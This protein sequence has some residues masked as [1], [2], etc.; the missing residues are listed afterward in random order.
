MRAF[1]DEVA[2]SLWTPWLDVYEALPEPLGLKFGR[3]YF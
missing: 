2:L 3:V 1:W